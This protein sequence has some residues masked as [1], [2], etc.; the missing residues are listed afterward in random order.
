MVPGSKK[1]SSSNPMSWA[2]INASSK[3]APKQVHTSTHSHETD[4]NALEAIT[5]QLAPEQSDAPT[6]TQEPLGGAEIHDSNTDFVLEGGIVEPFIETSVL[7]LVPEK[8][9]TVSA[10]VANIVICLA[11]TYILESL[12]IALGV[13]I[14]PVGGLNTTAMALSMIKK[15]IQ[16]LQKDVD[17]LMN[18]DYRTAFLRYQKA[19]TFMTNPETHKAA[20]KEYGKVVDLAERAYSQVKDFDKK[21]LCKKLALFGQLMTLMYEKGMETFL[22]LEKLS[23]SKKNTIAEYVYGEI[24][25]SIDDY[26]VVIS[27][28]DKGFSLFNQNRKTTMEKDKNQNL[29]DSLLKYGLPLMWHYNKVFQEEPKDSPVLL[30]FIPEHEDDAAEILMTSGQWIKVWKEKKQDEEE[31]FW[32]SPK[33]VSSSTDLKT[34]VGYVD[35]ILKCKFKCIDWSTSRFEDTYRFY[36]QEPREVKDDEER[37]CEVKLFFK[38]WEFPALVFR[39]EESTHI[40]ALETKSMSVVYYNMEPMDLFQDA[41]KAVLLLGSIESC[42][43]LIFSF[44]KIYTENVI[45]YEKNQCIP[46]EFLKNFFANLDKTKSVLNSE[47]VDSKKINAFLAKCQCIEIC[48]KKPFQFDHRHPSNMFNIINELENQAQ[49]LRPWYKKS[50][51]K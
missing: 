18:A 21:I 2:A 50:I 15:K 28:L 12:S 35:G 29:L 27:E 49:A 41:G 25:A 45:L 4:T 40:V 42:P 31:I 8:Y 11:N 33:N 30:Q 43:K 47:M 9:Q 46:R 22:P 37:S 17:K 14:N 5:T 34:Y 3:A 39:F 24:L 20:F 19:L 23:D 10:S 6:G 51:K 36:K 44:A 13:A 38:F 48:Q 7:M 16:Q 1:V 32:W 26:K